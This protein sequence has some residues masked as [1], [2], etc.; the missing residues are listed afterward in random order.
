MSDTE[1]ITQLVAAYG[2][3]V[4]AGDA[5]AV[6][7]LFTEDG[8]YDVSPSPL[9]GRE[10][11]RAMV[12]GEHHQALLARGCAHVM[13]LPRVVVEG[14]TE[15]ATHHSVVLVKEGDGFRVWRASANRWELVRTDDGWRATRRVNRP[16]DGSPDARAL[17]L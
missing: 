1:E 6:A 5:D 4:D 8:V 7:A 13:G 9:V 11:I 16:L 3:A 2:S 15:W 10:A 17:L 14:T 12:L